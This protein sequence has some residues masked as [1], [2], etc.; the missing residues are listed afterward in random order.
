MAEESESAPEQAMVP[1]PEEK[2]PRRRRRTPKE[3]QQA[4]AQADA[5]LPPFD[6]SIVDGEIH[7]TAKAGV[8]T[9]RYEGFDLMVT[10]QFGR[11]PRFSVQENVTMLGSLATQEVQ[12][13]VAVVRSQI[14][15]EK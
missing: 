4:R 15:V 11:D 1:V 6:A 2:Q 8:S 5:S 14:T 12:R 13:A 7:V 9:G 10:L 3:M